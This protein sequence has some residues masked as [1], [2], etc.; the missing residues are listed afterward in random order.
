MSQPLSSNPPDGASR[1]P[2][3]IWR[4]KAACLGA[5]PEQFFPIRVEA[6]WK[7]GKTRRTI[8]EYC[9]PCPVKAECLE[10]GMKERLGIWGG[11]T[12]KERMKLRVELKHNIRLMK[13]SD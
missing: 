3:A 12:P 8:N 6:G 11:T 7:G 5:E 4:K 10:E 1:T 9:V 2:V 13:P